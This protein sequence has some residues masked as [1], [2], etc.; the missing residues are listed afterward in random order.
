MRHATV[1]DLIYINDLLS[2]IRSIEKLREKNAG[3]FYFHG[4]NIAHFHVD[5]SI[6]YIDIGN[7]RIKV[8]KFNYDDILYKIKNYMYLIENGHDFNK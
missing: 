3:H 8:T 5:N 2:R 6:I 4:K 1:E 7:E